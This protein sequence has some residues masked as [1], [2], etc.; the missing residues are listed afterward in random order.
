MTLGGKGT[1]SPKIILEVYHI[2]QSQNTFSFQNHSS[3][4]ICEFP[5]PLNGSDINVT[6]MKEHFFP[7]TVVVIL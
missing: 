1:H 7:V 3:A 6:H 5:N 4:L 2:Y